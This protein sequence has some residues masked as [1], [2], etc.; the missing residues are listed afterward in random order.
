MRNFLEK[1][2]K[3]ATEKKEKESESRRGE[4]KIETT[5]SAH[6]R[7]RTVLIPW[8]PPLFLPLHGHQQHREQPLVEPGGERVKDWSWREKK[9]KKNRIQGTE[10]TDNRGDEE[11]S[12]LSLRP[13]S[14]R[15]LEPSA[16]AP[17]FL[18]V[19]TSY[20]PRDHHKEGRILL[21]QRMKNRG[22]KIF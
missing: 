15:C 16:A 9:G 8:E 11:N 14:L 19:F 20:T 10:K 3:Q 22:R 2:G 1:R 5:V 21:T 7:R 6:R 4:G 12:N 13:L 17:F 18:L